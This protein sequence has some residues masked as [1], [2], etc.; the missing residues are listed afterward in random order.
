MK[1]ILLSL[2]LILSLIF[3][4]S[5][6]IMA[7]EAENTYY[8]V[9]SEDSELALTLVSEGKSIVG[10]EK[11][12]SSRGDSIKEDSTYFLSQF[13]GKTLNLVLAEN[14]SYCMGT[15]P[16]N[17]I[18][19]GIRLDK[20]V[21][22]NVY[23]NGHYWWIPDDNR[24]AG[25]FVANEGATLSLIGDRTPEEIEAASTISST[26]N[27]KAP[28]NKVDFYAGYVG[29]Y[30]QAGNLTVKNAVIIGHDEVIY[31]KKYDAAQCFGTTVL[32]LENCAVYNKTNYKPI[33]LK[34]DGITDIK[35]EID[36]LYTEE[37]GINNIL[38]DSYISNS[39]MTSFYTDSWHTDE[40]IGK[41][42]IYV[43]NSTVGNYTCDGDTQHMVA[44]DSTFAKIDLNGDTTGGAYATLINSTYTSL[45]LIKQNNIASARHG[46]LYIVTP[47]TC[48]SAAQRTVYTYDDKSKTNVSSLD[49]QYSIDNPAT[50]HDT[51]NKPLS[52]S[53]TN[54][55]E[56][57]EAEY[58]CSACNAT[59]VASIDPLFVC[60]GYSAAESGARGI[61]VGYRT[62]NEILDLYEEITGKSLAYGVFAVSKNKIGANEIFDASGKASSGV[63]STL[64]DDYRF[65][66]FSLKIVGFTEEQKDKALAMGAYVKATDGEAVEYSYLQ[67]K[68]P[69]EN[70]K[71]H[72]VTYNEIMN[73]LAIQEMPF[74]DIEIEVGGTSSLPSTIL[75]D[76]KERKLSYTFDG[77]NISIEDYVLTGFTE[78]TETT[79]TASCKGIEV[80]FKVKVTSNAYK[81]VV[82]IGVDGAGAYFKDAN[83]PNIDAIFED[84][85]VTY[86]MLTSNPTISAQCWGSLLHGVEPT[87]HGLTNS[88]VESNAY[89]S[90]SKFPSF[91]RVIRE[92]DEDAVLASFTNWNPINVGIVENGIGV[93]KVGGISDSALTGEIIAYLAENNPTAMFVQFDGADG[94]GHTSGYGSQAQLDVISEIDA[95]IG[96]IYASYE[97]KGILNDTLFIVTADHGGNGKSHGGLTDGEKYVMFAAAGKTVQQGTIEDMEIRDTAAVVLYALGY[98][99]HENWTA[100][101]PSGLFEG[102]VAGERPVYVNKDS[103]R[104]HENEMTP[105]KGS[106]GYVTNFVDNELK[107]YLT[108]DGDVTDNQGGST[109]ENGKLYYV[110][111]YYGQGA[112]FD[113]GYVTLNGCTLGKDSF[114]VAFWI[115]TQGVSSDPCIISNKNW[116]SGKNS[117]LTIAINGSDNDIRLNLGNGGTRADCN[118]SLPSNYR[119]G[120][121]HII[122]VVDRERNKLGICIDFETYVEVD[123]PSG[124]WET[125][126]DTSYPLNIGQDGRGT[127]NAK[128]SATL[129]ELMIFDGAFGESDIQALASYFGITD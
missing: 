119:E 117:G 57:G 104:Y 84:G 114:T 55:L 34:A 66:M 47:A 86:N 60:L 93:Y 70:E 95:Y 62:N 41:E 99:S 61:T 102:V 105:E 28:S 4:F 120:W 111:G 126:F 13:D 19:S 64:I 43:N 59:Y 97:A 101:V 38:S 40:Y 100:R 32:H 74:E 20:A 58:V 77:S 90:D 26:V 16:S 113:D 122:A 127:Y 85:A 109:E 83:T 71:Y 87:L 50:G 51:E 39:K 18:G 30:V 3:A 116:D 24:Y 15:N 106:D 27:A 21:T 72:F 69:N 48:Q 103:E 56:N 11:L 107:A 14:V 10:I 23:F 44:T 80:S 45:Y 121:M 37:I 125:S 108:F 67:S 81:H 73:E 68:S 76:G 36:H 78:N 123:I 98:E 35:A 49:E 22:L 52:I 65:M 124:L 128:L 25:F 17:P 29:L 2:A 9:Q 46:I 42:Y 33:D 54:Y 82:V 8:V 79:V 129:D 91:F 7:S 115:N 12:Y 5:V 118:V 88:I 94:A 89:P 92:N 53:Y 75:V 96:Q 112:A 110:E 31:Q 6:V 1:K 63:I